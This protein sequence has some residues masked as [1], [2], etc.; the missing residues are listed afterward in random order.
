MGIDEFGNSA[1]ADA[2]ADSGT[3]AE[4]PPDQASGQRPEQP[5][6][7][8]AEDAGEA[9]R[10]REPSETLTR[11]EYADHMRSQGS[12][13]P[14]DDDS[15]RDSARSEERTD[16]D[17]YA[18]VGEAAGPKESDSELGEE[19]DQAE[20]RD[21]ETYADDMRSDGAPP[22]HDDE[23]AGPDHEPADAAP[24]AA[25]RDE[26]DAGQEGTEPLSREEYADRMHDAQPRDA[27]GEQTAEGSDSGEAD[28]AL[29]A[30]PPDTAY[31][32]KDEA[33][34]ETDVEGKATEDPQV[35][36][37]Q[38]P[39]RGDHV[40]DHETR[41]HAQDKA[42]VD[43]H[44]IEVSHDP[45]DGVWIE[46]LPGEV[47]DKAGEVFAGAE[48]RKRSRAEKVLGWAVEKGDDVSDSTE[49]NVNLLSD[50]FERPPTHAEVPVQVAYYSAPMQHTEI[51]PGNLATTALAMSIMA[52]AGGRWL[53]GKLKGADSARN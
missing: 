5:E 14:R 23:A 33:S 42:Y 3:S 4:R 13:I 18:D 11:E 21:R 17:G 30:T 45:A 31:G 44:E 22:V 29:T 25:N 20:T 6:T 12:P 10:R 19:R 34:D 1:G 9:E 24:D 2:S 15:D 37:D 16:A 28:S 7:Q 36:A 53:H 52:C 27:D 38:Q 43:G 41:D 51:D 35:A 48:E 46:G 47:P 50:V 26:R 8:P 32:G 49:S 39:S 40:A